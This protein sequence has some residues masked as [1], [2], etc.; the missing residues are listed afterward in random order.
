M[1]TK[2]KI[3]GIRHLVSAQAAIDAGADFLGFNFVRGYS[4]LINEDMAK[5]IMEKIKNVIPIVGIFQNADIDYVNRMTEYLHL[6]YVQLHG[7]EGVKYVRKVQTRVIKAFDFHDGS[8]AEKMVEKMKSY[9]VSYH[10]LDIKKNSA[11]RITNYIPQVK[12]IAKKIPIFVAGGLDSDNVLD[13]INIIQ[14]YGV[15]VARGIET[16]G[17]EDLAKIYKFTTLVKNIN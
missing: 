9:E 2:V 10:L 5:I 15:D 12:N 3:C 11:E 16:N 14:P 7:D 1:K 13:L 6:D 4:H 8:D 17:K